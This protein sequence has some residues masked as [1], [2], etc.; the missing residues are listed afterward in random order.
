MTNIFHEIQLDLGKN[1]FQ[2][3][4]QQTHFEHIGKGRLGNQLIEMENNKIPII[5]S[6]AKF[7]TP[8]NVFTTLHHKIIDLASSKFKEKGIEHVHFNN[9]L[10][11]IYED[12][13]RKMKYHSDHRLDLDSDSYIGLF[14]CYENEQEVTVDHV[15]KLKVKHKAC[16]TESEILLWPNSFVLFSTQANSQYHHKIV[17]DFVQPTKKTSKNKWLGITF[18]LSKTFIEFKNNKP[19]F[20]NGTELVKPDEESEKAFYQLRGAD[21]RNIEFDYPEINF[22]I[23]PA[24]FINISPISPLRY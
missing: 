6:T 1:P 12:E 2:E 24:D 11:E 16:Q 4:S 23:N 7:T 17:K 19:Y 15:R 13:Y 20:E 14:S 22:S 8:Y 21:N 10:I 18:R 9:A 3:L 5:R